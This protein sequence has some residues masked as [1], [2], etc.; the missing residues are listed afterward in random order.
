[1]ASARP[2]RRRQLRLHFCRSEGEGRSQ[3]NSSTSWGAVAFITKA[4]L[5]RL[6]PRT[7]WLPGRPDISNWDP[8]KDTWELYNLDED[9]SQANDLAAKM[10]DKLAAMKA[11][12]LVES[13]KNQNLP[14]GGGLWT[15]THPEDIPATPYTDWTFSGPISRMPE[16]AAPKLGKFN[17]VVSLEV[18]VPASANGV[19]YALEPSR[20]ASPAI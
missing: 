11:L 6:G 15:V 18:E 19:L 2:D 10:P 14:I 16:F 20:A 4:G 13:A 17:N 3:R 8:E 9:W 7:P 5:P 12:F 1:M